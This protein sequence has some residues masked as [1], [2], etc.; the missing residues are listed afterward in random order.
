MLDKLTN[1]KSL[2]FTID[3]TLQEI[4]RAFALYL[5]TFCF[6]LFN[7][8]IL[9]QSIANSNS[10]ESLSEIASAQISR[11]TL[12]EVFP[13][14][15][16]FFISN[17]VFFV[18]VKFLGMEK[19]QE[20][21]NQVYQKLT[22]SSNQFAKEIHTG[23]PFYLSAI[24]LAFVVLSL[25]TFINSSFH[26]LID[27][28]ISTQH[29]LKTYCYNQGSFLGLCIISAISKKLINFPACNALYNADKVTDI[30]YILCLNQ[31]GGL[32]IEIFK[33]ILI[34]LF[35][36]GSFRLFLM[37]LQVTNSRSLYRT[38]LLLNKLIKHKIRQ[39]K[40]LFIIRLIYM[41]VI[42]SIGN[43][44]GIALNQILAGVL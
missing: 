31:N 27:R 36:I 28:H 4:L 41:F 13:P 12:I 15:A 11:K 18:L 37:T 23:I 30:G 40:F 39:V 44:A 42:I 26:R 33:Y 35:A 3:H 20:L 17:T 19:D 16:Y 2:L 25:H 10:T 9:Y 21:F 29:I 5:R 32:Y 34:I 38:S 14:I 22:I 1:P 43:Y 8:K 24:V 7:P 6:L